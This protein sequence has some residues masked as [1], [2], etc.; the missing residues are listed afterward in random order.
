[1][2]LVVT[3]L[4]DLATTPLT[5][6]KVSSTWLILWKFAVVVTSG[7]GECGAYNWLKREPAP[8]A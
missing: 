1:L 5:M 8:N 2:A 7:T 6:P 4:I 3:F